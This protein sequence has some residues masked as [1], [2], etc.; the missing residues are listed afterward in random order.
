MKTTTLITVT[1]II[2]S[3]LT[4]S[5]DK[6]DSKPEIDF[7][8][9]GF[10]NSKTAVAGDELHMDAEIVAENQIDRIEIEIHP[11]G[12]GHKNAALNLLSEEEW[13][14]DTVYTKFSGLKN[15]HFHEHIEVPEDVEPEHYHFHFAVTDM[16]G[17]QT[18]FEEE[19]EILAPVKK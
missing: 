8:E 11:E 1:V 3:M 15:T 19:V 6:T 10:D 4:I 18:V 2:L 7:H 9:L 5:C 17:N 16:E 12:D 13:E 14:F